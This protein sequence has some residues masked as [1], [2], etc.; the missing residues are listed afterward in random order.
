MGRP[1]TID[2]N[3]LDPTL[4]LRWPGSGSRVWR[5]FL[6]EDVALRRKRLHAWQL[7]FTASVPVGVVDELAVP[8]PAGA[9]PGPPLPTDGR[10]G[11]RCWS[12]STA[13]ASSSA[14]STSHDRLCRSFAV[15]AGI[16]VFSVD[17]RLAPE[18][19]APA[20]RGRRLCG[21]RW[22][23]EHAAEFG[24]D[25]GVV[26]V[27]GDSAGGNLAAAVAQRGRDDGAPPRC[28][29]CYTRS[30]TSRGDT[31]SR[32]LF[33]DGF[34]LTQLGHGLVPRTSTSAAR[35]IDATDPRVS[36]LLADDL[37]GLPP[38]LVITAGFDP[39]RDE[40]R[41]YAAAMRDAGR[42]RRP[43]RGRFVDARLRQFVRAGWRR[44]IAA[45]RDHL[46]AA[47]ASVHR[48]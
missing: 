2:G 7:G 3:T 1:V 4:Q 13:A 6:S 24:A 9:D 36:P 26:A 8:G 42:D 35:G 28:R 25:P 30:P 11:R 17:Y 18:H 22:A 48:S 10:P 23:L 15:G 47:R 29:C 33:A 12:I 16:H 5:A 27:G 19:P 21:V 41:Q 20:G 45:G 31:R 40:G 43:A 14:T 34:F 37:S 44:A 46:R 39:L 32:T 38:A